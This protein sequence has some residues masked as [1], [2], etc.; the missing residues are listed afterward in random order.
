MATTGQE[1]IGSEVINRLSIPLCRTGVILKKVHGP[2]II[3]V[4]AAGCDLLWARETGQQP[5]REQASGKPLTTCPQR[6]MRAKFSQTFPH[7]YFLVVL[8]ASLI[9]ST[10]LSFCSVHFIASLSLSF[11]ERDWSVS[12]NVKLHSS[13]ILLLYCLLSKWCR[14]SRE[15]YI[16][17]GSLACGFN[18]EVWTPWRH[19]FPVAGMKLDELWMSSGL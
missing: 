6:Q 15:N 19:G 13:N 8:I 5:V 3:V 17:C 7:S 12:F 11:C 14:H 2:V 10:P 16:N 18:A 9:V 1:T 4:L